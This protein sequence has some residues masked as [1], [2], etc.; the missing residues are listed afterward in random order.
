MLLIFITEAFQCTDNR[1]RGTLAETAQSHALNHGRKFFQFVE[2]GHLALA[3]Y[4]LLEDLEHTFGT[5]TARN[6]FTAALTLCKVHEES[7]NFNHT[8]ILV[9]NYETA[10]THDRIERF[11]RIKVQRTVDLIFDQTSTGW[12]TDLYTFESSSALQA[13]TDIINDMT[14]TGTH[15]YFDQTCVFNCTG[16]GEGLGSRA[17]FCSNGTEP[18]RTLKNDLRNVC[19]CFY[20]IQNSR[21]LPETFFYC[22][23]WFDT[24]HAS[25]T[26]DGCSEGRTFTTNKGTCTTI[27]M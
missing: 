20:V 19:I 26:F 9:H 25:L 2:I 12:S 22:T 18:V 15:W 1:K 16:Q 5:L 3:I 17:S 27:D 24:R 7:G 4:D 11:D 21:F 8:G 13:T 10:R 6:A 23:R 14:K